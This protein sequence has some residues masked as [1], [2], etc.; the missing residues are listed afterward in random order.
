MKAKTKSDELQQEAD[1]MERIHD[2]PDAPTQTDI[3]ERIRQR[4]YDI[5]QNRSAEGDELSDWY[6]AEAE[7]YAALGPAEFEEKPESQNRAVA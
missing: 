7:I 5:S 6:Q 1:A 3:Q 4:A 2:S